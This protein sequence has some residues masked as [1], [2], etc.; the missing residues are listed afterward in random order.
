MVIKHPQQRKTHLL[1][2]FL[3]L[4]LALPAFAQSSGL[5]CPAMTKLKLSQIAAITEMLQRQQSELHHL[6]EVHMQALAGSNRG[7]G[8]RAAKRMSD[9]RQTLL[10]RQASERLELMREQS[11]SRSLIRC[12]TLAPNLAIYERWKDGFVWDKETGTMQG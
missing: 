8:P 4:L 7:H 6:V 5:E 2:I 1:S 11:Q 9:E 12:R 3:S 10:D